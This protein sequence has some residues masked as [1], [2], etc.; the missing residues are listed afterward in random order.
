M[1]WHLHLLDGFLDRASSKEVVV[2]HIQS[3]GMAKVA[4]MQA[5]VARWKAG[6]HR[7]VNSLD[8][9]VSIVHQYDRYPEI[10]SFYFKKVRAMI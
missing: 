1:L 4:N 3:Q 10:Q 7:V 2:S 5:H 8:E 9:E 6:E